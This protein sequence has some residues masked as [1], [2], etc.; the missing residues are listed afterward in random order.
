MKPSVTR[1]ALLSR[2]AIIGLQFVSNRLIP[3]HDA[4]VFVSPEDP[5]SKRPLDAWIHFF[6]GG[7]RRWDAQYYLHIAE[8]GYTYENSLAFYPLYPALI[9][10][11][12][13]S[14]RSL[15]MLDP[16]VSFRELGLVVALAINVYFFVK[17]A[18]ALARLTDDTFRNG[19]AT[20]SATIL[21][22][23]NPA[24]VFF[25]APYTE[26]LFAWLTFSLILNCKQK[27]FN[28]VLLPLVLSIL[29]RS[30]GL[31]NLGFPVFYIVQ[32]ML[33]KKLLWNHLLKL[34]FSLQTTLLTF[35]LLQY[36]Q[37]TLFCRD[38]DNHYSNVITNYAIQHNLVLAGTFSRTNSTWCHQS[39]PMAY[40]YIQKHYW[41]VGFLSYYQLKQIPNFALAAPII[42]VFISNIFSYT[43]RHLKQ[44]ITSPRHL[45]HLLQDQRTIEQRLL[46]HVV[47]STVLVLL[48]V[49][50]VHI[51][52]STRLL[53]SATP[54]LYW[55]CH[56]NAIPKSVR[57]FRLA[58]NKTSQLTLLWCVGYILLGTILFCNFLPWT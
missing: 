37:Y 38:Q 18:Q 25:S 7:F 22:C 33:A 27:R 28:H 29:C 31:I 4:G 55:F 20:N 17:A 35:G 16:L 10:G 19:K 13:R 47:H 56:I 54:C 9:N 5:Q 24:S 51:Q 45:V 52:V 43:R 8:H 34:T 26:S 2:I 50:F 48:C 49:C 12:T 40:N 11:A 23:I 32:D 6:F 30:N 21:F 53:A 3:D 36:Y 15:L 39:I 1:L 42:C 44:I 41:D 14:A 58:L 46:V 57:E